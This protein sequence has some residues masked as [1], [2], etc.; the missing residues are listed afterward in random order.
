MAKK[1][2]K[3]SE[4]KKPSLLIPRSEANVQIKQQIEKLTKL[5]TES[6]IEHARTKLDQYADYNKELLGRMFDNGV[7]AREYRGAINNVHNIRHAGYTWGRVAEPEAN[8]FKRE[9]QENIKVL[10]NI[11]E[12]LELIPELSKV[13]STER[14]KIEFGSDI[15]IVHGH[16]EAA[17]EK[18]AGF[19]KALDLNPIILH[20]KPNKGRTIIEKFEDYANVCF[21][22]VLLTPDDVGASATNRDNLQ[23]RARQNVVFELGFFLGKLGRERVCALYKGEVEI[24]SDYN[25]ILFVPM[26]ENDGWKL[27]LAKELKA[28]GISI[29]L[30]KTIE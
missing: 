12:R 3:P 16:D 28:A 18:V 25:G 26:D 30:G 2:T 11:N 7:I 22:V 4:P 17:K 6:D 23:N 1:T 24:F 27:K 14:P 10:E 5:L 8:K 15:F 20:E 13:S 29:D 9:V 19:I 21:A